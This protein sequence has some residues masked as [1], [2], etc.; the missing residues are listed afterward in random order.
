MRPSRWDPLPAAHDR[1]APPVLHRGT[2]TQPDRPFGVSCRRGGCDMRSP[3]ADRERERLIEAILPDVAF[4]GWSR[5]ALREAARRAGIS[6]GEAEALFPRGAPDLVAA[7]SEWADR[8]V[9]E[10]LE[11]ATA[12]PVS[13]SRRVAL[14]LRLRFEVLLPYRET[15]RRSLSVLSMP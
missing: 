3:F 6:A 15:V 1:S 10:R 4:D 8:Q 14:A 11:H 5:H 9:L 7:F 2:A 13:L 12:E